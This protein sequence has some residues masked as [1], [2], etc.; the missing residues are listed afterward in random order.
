MAGRARVGPPYDAALQL[1]GW[2]FA[3]LDYLTGR[4]IDHGVDPASLSASDWL[5]LAMARLVDMSDGL[6]DRAKVLESVRAVLAVPVVTTE[7][8]LERMRRTWGRS[9]QAQ[10]GQRAM[11]A[12][13]G[14]P[15]PMRDPNQQRPE[16]WKSRE[17]D[18]P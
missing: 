10:A 17:D 14:G 11:M 12:A 4:L 9:P 16:A 5:D 7:T 1:A 2:A 6:T 15:A 3:H 18:S 13:A 8:A